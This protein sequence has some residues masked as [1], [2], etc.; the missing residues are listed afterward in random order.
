MF[1]KNRWAIFVPT[2]CTPTRLDISQRKFFLTTKF[3]MSNQIASSSEIS[4]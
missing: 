1:K 3:S 4:F 2:S